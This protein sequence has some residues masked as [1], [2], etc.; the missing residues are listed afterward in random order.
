MEAHLKQIGQNKLI[1]KKSIETKKRE[2]Q[3][4]MQKMKEFEDKDVER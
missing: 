2:E 4:F 3:E 1:E